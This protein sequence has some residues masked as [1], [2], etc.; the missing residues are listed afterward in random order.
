[1]EITYRNYRP[2]DRSQLEKYARS[3]VEYAAETN[4]LRLPTPKSGYE[5]LYLDWIE[6][7]LLTGKAVFLVAEADGKIAGYTFGYIDEHA[8][9]ERLEYKDEKVGY[10]EDFY[11]NDDYR[12]QGIG[13]E[14]LT[15]IEGAFKAMG[16]V[17][18]TLHTSTMRPA[19]GFYQKHG[20]KDFIV[21]MYKEI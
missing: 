6:S 16:C 14:L 5:K 4:P 10:I 8:T 13:T 19:H 18:L 15:R 7:K 9:E 11:I 20:L 17:V 21:K 3:L 1:M 12:G 2:A